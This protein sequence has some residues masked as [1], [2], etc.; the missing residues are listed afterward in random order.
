MTPSP[1]SSPASPES[2]LQ[3]VGKSLRPRASAQE[4]VRQAMFSRMRAP[5]LLNQAKDAVTPDASLVTRVWSNISHS[6]D[7][8]G[9][10]LWDRVRGNLA[11]PEALREYLWSRLSGRL[12]PQHAH[13]VVSRPIKWIAAV[14]VVVVAVRASPMLFLAPESIAESPV[15]LIAQQGKVEVL[16]DTESFWQQV[17]GEVLLR[18][19]ARLQTGASTATIVSHDDAVF[20]LAPFTRVALKDMSDRPASSEQEATLILDDGKMWV[21]GLVPK[22]VRGITIVTAQG[23]VDIH[24]GSVSIEQKDGVV[25]IEVLNRS[26][27]V[28]RHGKQLGLLTGEKTVLS[29]GDQ[30]VSTKLPHERFQEE[31]VAINLSRDAA[32]Q[33]EIAQLQQERRA[34][35]AGI[36]PKT[37]FYPVKRLAEKMDVLLSF[38]EEE[39]ARKLI[40]QANT[41]LN[42][43]AALLQTGDT[44][45]AESALE[46]YKE[47]LLT[48]ASGTGGSPA[49]RSLLQKEVVEEG[50]ATVSAALPG[51]SAYALK[52]AV[53]NTIAALPSNDVVAKPDVEGEALLDQLVAVKRQAEQGNTETAKEKLTQ[54]SDSLQAL[55]VTG[56]LVL[57]SPEIREEAAAT[58]EHVVTVIDPPARSLI[59]T[60]G[61]PKKEIVVPSAHSR[62]GVLNRVLTPDQVAAKAQE[63]RGR[64]FHFESRKDQYDALVDQLRILE[65]HPD[66]GSILRKLAESMPKNG[67]WQR[68]QREIRIV[69]AEVEAQ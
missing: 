23:R 67:L 60:L 4:R 61:A 8:V 16:D 39:R 36:L 56:A 52:Q 62:T 40:T 19:Q 64:I 46:Q 57:M 35:S 17:E 51:D 22:H 65:R 45:E 25:T 24:E 33:Q 34:R 43:A 44:V 18:S 14:A 32:H 55:N 48:V 29:G 12:Q 63:I 68:V 59:L 38:G 5:S 10:S 2:L 9:S 26:A 54:M 49:V 11:P 28:S 41:R 30:F 42:E 50:A 37:A 66:R 6:I 1:F 3:S 15:L 27:V 58:M 21:L 53:G 31:W 47:T 69:G 20:R 7:P 13:P